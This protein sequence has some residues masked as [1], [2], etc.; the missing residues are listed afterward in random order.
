L[1]QLLRVDSDFSD[2][3]AVDLTVVAKFASVLET[4]YQTATQLPKETNQANYETSVSPYI[5]ALRR[6]LV[7]VKQWADAVKNLAAS[8]VSDLSARRALK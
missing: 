1:S 8:S 7:V 5:G 4:L 6:Q 2:L 3:K